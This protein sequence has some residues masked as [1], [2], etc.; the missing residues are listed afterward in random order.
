MSKLKSVK[1][2]SLGMGIAVAI[3]M[4]IAAIIVSDIEFGGDIQTIFKCYMED[5]ANSGGEVTQT[6]YKEFDGEVPAEKWEEYFGHMTIEELP[7]SYA[8]V[9]DANTGNFLFHPTKDKIGT[10]VTND[11][12]KELVKNIETK[13]SFTPKDYVEYE[14]KGEMKMAAYSV[15]ADDNYICVMT[16]DK[17]DITNSINAV[18]MKFV[19]IASAIAVVLSIIVFVVL[20]KLI[21]PLG[22]VTKVVEQLSSFNLTDDEAQ[23][24]RL[25]SIQN[26]VGQIAT[27]VRDLRTALRTTV[28]G[29]VDNSTKL[30]QFSNELAEESE[31][32]TEYVTSIDTACNEIA[33]GATGQAHS[34][35]NATNKAMNMGELIDSS[36]SAVDELKRVSEEVKEATYSAGNKLT[37][38]KASNQKVTEVTE[39]IGVSI[40]ETSKSAEKIREAAEVITNIASQTNLLSLNASIEAARAGDAGRGFAVVA[41]EIS[42]LSD[43]SNQA[44]VEIRNIISELISNSDQS[45]ADIQEAKGIT[46]EQTEKLEDAMSEFGRA[47]NGL[48][49]SLTEIEKVKDSTKELD[50][51]KNE[52]IDIIQS[53]AAISEE[54]AASTEE[55]AASVT[56]AKSVIEQVANK[57]VDIKTASL[58]LADSAEKWVL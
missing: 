11:I 45:V 3:I 48:D 15:V 51:S 57:A 41:S 8:Y 19:G 21:N 46:E 18:L 34:T 6:L 10:E 2:I 55:T 39:K 14:Y 53:L 47:K 38:V 22:E 35:E 4:T 52:V 17:K 43:Q 25:C 42:Q 31:S 13:S 9:V 49:K 29:L 26:E 58:E 27:A 37:D 50:S 5:M 23:T 56:Q 32:V 30:E 28:S 20:S 16:A 24:N 33:E 36:I 1:T 54:N 7:S 44:A 12:I 40:A